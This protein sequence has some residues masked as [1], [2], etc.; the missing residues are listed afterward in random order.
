MRVFVFVCVCVC[1]FECVWVCVCMVCVC[2]C[3][4]VC[5][6]LHMCVCLCVCVLVCACVCVCVCVFSVCVCVCVLAYQYAHNYKFADMQADVE[7]GAALAPEVRAPSPGDIAA[8][9]EP[10]A[11]AFAAGTSLQ[12]RSGPMPCARILGGAVCSGRSCLISR[13]AA[14]RCTVVP[15]ERRRDQYYRRGR[16]EG[17]H[18]GRKRGEWYEQQRCVTLCRLMYRVRCVAFDKK[19]VVCDL[20]IS[21]V[22]H[23]CCACPRTCDT[24]WSRVQLE[25]RWLLLRRAAFSG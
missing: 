14:H 23:Y 22:L 4:C 2:V 7:A 13:C 16:A 18:F 17:A 3:V 5:M 1:V 8:A 11:D 25:I 12:P 15:C 19:L 21:H 6:C 9:R 10:Q 24:V 20:S